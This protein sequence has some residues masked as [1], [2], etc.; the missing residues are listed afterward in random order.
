[1]QKYNPEIHKPRTGWDK[2]SIEM[3]R[4]EGHELFVDDNGEVWTANKKIFAGKIRK[5]EPAC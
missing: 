4:E 2:T 1:M 3:V 5:E